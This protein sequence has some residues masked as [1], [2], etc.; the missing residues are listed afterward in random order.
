MKQPL[1]KQLLEWLS[2]NGYNYLVAENQAQFD[3]YEFIPVK[4]NID[5]FQNA[6][7]DYAFDKNIILSITDA[8]HSFHLEDYS[9]HDVIL[10]EE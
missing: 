5:D 9:N 10:P 6:T 4:W 7:M 8:L 1:T 2:L 3:Y